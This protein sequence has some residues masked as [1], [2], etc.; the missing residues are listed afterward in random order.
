ML[1][2]VLRQEGFDA[3]LVERGDEAME[4]FHAYRPDVVLL[5][6]MLARQGRDRRLQ[7]DPRRV[8]GADRDAHR[9][10][11]T[12]DVVVGLE[13]GADD[14]VVKPFKPKELVA[15]IRAR[16]RRNDSPGAGSLAVGPAQHRRS[17]VIP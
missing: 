4:A 15:R 16:I 14:Y 12:V 13:S 2:I 11:D 3:H 1:S 5:D 7:G 17:L 9:Q 6:L 10:G 8:R